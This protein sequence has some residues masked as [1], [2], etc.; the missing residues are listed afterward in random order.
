[1]ENEASVFP[2][3]LNRSHRVLVFSIEL[4]WPE[5]A[6]TLIRTGFVPNAPPELSQTECEQALGTAVGQRARLFT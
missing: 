6:A 5:S 3:G 1:M 4:N 2:A